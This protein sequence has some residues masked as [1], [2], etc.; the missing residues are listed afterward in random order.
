MCK[1]DGRRL[2][3]VVFGVDVLLFDLGISPRK[4]DVEYGGSVNVFEVRGQEMRDNSLLGHMLYLPYF[5]TRRDQWPYIIYL[6]KY[7]Y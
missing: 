2:Q 6:N 1:T 7:V 4:K 5:I 3:L